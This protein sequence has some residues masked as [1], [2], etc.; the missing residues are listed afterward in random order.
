MKDKHDIVEL[1]RLT[2]AIRKLKAQR[3]KKFGINWHDKLINKTGYRWDEATRQQYIR[4]IEEY[5]ALNNLTKTQAMRNIGIYWNV[6]DRLKAKQINVKSQN[7]I[8]SFF[9][10]NE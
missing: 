4:K 5:I 8:E 2:E 7:T 1:V 9:K 3:I 6:F 10:E